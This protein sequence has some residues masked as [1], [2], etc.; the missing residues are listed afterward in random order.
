MGIR[1]PVSQTRKI[2]YYCWTSIANCLKSYEKRRRRDAQRT[3]TYHFMGY[4]TLYP[5]YHFPERVRMRL[6]YEIS[7]LARTCAKIHLFITSQFVIL[8]PYQ[9]KGHGG[10]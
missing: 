7:V 9:H 6:R 4:S 1:S 5:F 3:A 10:K 2:V 8:P